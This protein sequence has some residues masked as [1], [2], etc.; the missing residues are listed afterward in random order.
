MEYPRATV[1]ERTWD[2][3]IEKAASGDY[4]PAQKYIDVKEES[5]TTSKKHKSKAKK[6]SGGKKR[7]G[8]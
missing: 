3:I 2:K 7:V 4:S 1:S 6:S 8:L 5:H